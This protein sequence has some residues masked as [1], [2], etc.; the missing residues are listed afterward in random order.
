M[1]ITH[2]CLCG[3]VT[4]NWTYQDNLLP[5]YHKKLGYEVSV[6]TSRYVFNDKGQLV[7]DKRSEYINEHG[8]KIIRIENKYRTTI[9]S[10]FKIYDNLY[11]T[12]EEEKPEILF[13]HGVQ[14]I[15]LEF[16]K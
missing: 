15:N 16:G 5:K 6:I 10:K 8:V 9:N 7:I 1:K 11:K 4:D 14:F 3:P 12:I 2:I 13:I